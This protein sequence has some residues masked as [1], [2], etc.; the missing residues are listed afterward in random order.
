MSSLLSNQRNFCHLTLTLAAACILFNTQNA[1]AD[2]RGPLPPPPER[3]AIWQESFDEDYFSGETNVELIVPGFGFLDQ[4]WSGYALVRT[5]GAVVPFTIPALD[6]TGHTNVSSDTAGALRFW[7]E[8]AWASQSANG[9]GP[10]TNAVLIE[11][12]ASSAGETAFAWALEVSADGN[13]LAL[14]APTASEIETLLQSQISWQTNESHCI[15]LD[16]STNGSE[17]YV[18]GQPVAQSVPLPSVPPSIGELTLGSTISGS[19]PTEGILDEVYS[20]DHWLSDSDVAAYYGMTYQE[21][22]LG[23]LAPEE[24]TGISQPVEHH[25]NDIHSRGNV[26]DSNDNPP[27]SPGGLMYINN[28][29]ATPETNGTTTISFSVQGG[30]NGVFYDLFATPTLNAFLPDYQWTWIGQVL[31]CNDYTFTGQPAGQA[32]YA[33]ELP[34]LTFTVAFGNNAEGQCNVPANL[35]NTV[36]VAGGSNYSVALRN[37]GIVVAWG[38]NTYG[39]TNIPAGLSNVTAIAGGL[40]HGVALLSN[41]SVTNWGSYWDGTTYLTSVTNRTYASAPPLSNVMAVA[42]GMGQDLALLSNGTCV[43]WGFTNVY[44]TGAAFGTL[45]PTNLNLTNV[46][47]IACGWGFNVALSS[48]GAVTAWGDDYAGIY[49]TTNLP[50]DLSSNVVAIAAGGLNGLALRKNGTVE[51]WGAGTNDGVYVTNVPAGLTNVVAIAT[52]GNVGLALQADGTP[53][54]WGESSLTNYSNWDGCGQSD[55]HRLRAQHRHRIGPIGSRAL[56]RTD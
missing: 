25:A 15:A 41:G 44:G 52:G 20:F 36:A 5:G 13:T 34:A 46:S 54:A 43:A 2:P 23:P 22:A 17:L 31:T 14:V 7:V 56:F 6:S 32:F 10:E 19:N 38:D 40:L 16:F 39:Q 42:A 35:T 26:Y 11:F 50:S 1:D 3:P 18:D 9:T 8:P 12:D 33:L 51:G 24:S 29:V 21:A 28:L 53:V 30:T 47:A 37:N 48:N 49:N 55:C 4:S 45:V 27:C